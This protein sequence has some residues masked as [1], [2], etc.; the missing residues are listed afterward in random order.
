MRRG[1]S[2]NICAIVLWLERGEGVSRSDASAK[3]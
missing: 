3:N 1:S 2:D